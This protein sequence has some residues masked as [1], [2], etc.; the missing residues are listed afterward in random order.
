MIPLPVPALRAPA[1]FF[2]FISG[3]LSIKIGIADFLQYVSAGLLFDNGK[4]KRLLHW[5]PRYDLK[6]GVEEMIQGWSRT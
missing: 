5:E 6:K 2:D 1:L 4:A 3:L